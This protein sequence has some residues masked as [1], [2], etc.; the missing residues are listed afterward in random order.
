MAAGLYVSFYYLGGS[1]GA[2]LLGRLWKC[3]GWPACVASV[4]VLQAISAAVALRF[5]SASTREPA[6]RMDVEPDVLSQQ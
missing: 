6:G 4:A 2:T 5:F 1:V 3:G